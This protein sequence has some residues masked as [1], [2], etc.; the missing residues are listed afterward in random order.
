M[1]IYQLHKHGGLWEDYRDNIIGSYVR[2]ERAEEEKLKAEKEEKIKRQQAEKCAEC[3]YNC[4]I[5]DNA[6]IADLMRKHCDHSDIIFEDD[7]IYCKAHYYHWRDY[8][9]YVEEVEVDEK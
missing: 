4:N 3:P 8:E 7:E 9:F 2:K 6:V 1:K 5:T